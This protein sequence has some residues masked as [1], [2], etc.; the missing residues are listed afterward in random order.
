MVST[1]KTL[2]TYFRST[3]IFSLC[4]SKGTNCEKENAI[5]DISV[6]YNDN[7]V[8]I[9][10]SMNDLLSETESISS[11]TSISLPKKFKVHETKE[12]KSIT[13]ED[14]SVT[15]YSGYLTYK[16]TSK[17]NG[18][19]CKASSESTK[20]MNNQFNC[21]Y[22]IKIIQISTKMRVSKHQLIFLTA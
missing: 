22:Y 12:T 1:S 19:M 11:L 5:D 17:F 16:C 13:I 20:N 3:C 15:Y 14:C 4:Q 21:L 6:I 7:D 2:I 9:T 18:K 8:T 10:E